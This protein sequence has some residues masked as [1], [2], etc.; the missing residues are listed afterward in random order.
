M[1]PDAAPSAG[2][3]AW[4]GGWP[5]TAEEFEQLVEVFQHALTGFAFHRLGNLAD[6]EDVAQEVFV[7]AFADRGKRQ[8]VA[9]VG[10]YLYRMAANLCVDFLRRRK[11]RPSVS[12]EEA[13]VVEIPSHDPGA[14]R[15]AEAAEEAGRIERLL[16]RIP[17]RQ[18]EAVRLCIIDELKPREAAEILNC[19]EAT[20]KSRV[21]YGLEKLRGLVQ[22]KEEGAR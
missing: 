19:P 5:G 1:A 7:R 2:S 12:L 17:K 22:R 9:N 15:L 21:R 20:I 6:A 8:T 4:E 10:A 18:A 14:V 16:G 3:A 13:R 11:R